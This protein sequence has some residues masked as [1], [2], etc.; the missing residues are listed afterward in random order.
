MKRLINRLPITRIKI[1]IGRILYRLVH[2]MY[3]QD[4]RVIVRGGIKYEI[5][6]SEGIDL[7]LFLFGNF[8]KHVSQNKSLSLPRDAVIFDV[9]ANFG[10]M[11]LQFAQLVPVG[12]VYSFEPTF[13]AFSKLKK[14]LEL[15]PDLAKRIVAIQS[16]VSSGTSPRH[17]IKAYASWKVGGTVEGPKHRVHGGIAKSADGVGTVSLD[18]FCKQNEIERL[19][20]IKIDTDGHEFEVLKGAQKIIR[21]F[22]PLIIFEIGMY[23]MEEREISFSDYLE[24]FRSLNYSLFNSS[25]FKGINANNYRRHIPQKGTIDILARRNT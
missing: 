9:G 14:N 10:L 23:V 16:F 24:L 19:D 11:T 17:D 25:N 22:N 7:S 3:R 21:E 20:F 6:L 1:F 4:R 5:D 12:K 8:Q 15:N 18:D 2:L 13:Y